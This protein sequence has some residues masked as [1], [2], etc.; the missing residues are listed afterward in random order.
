VPLFEGCIVLA[1]WSGSRITSKYPAKVVTIKT[2]G[3]IGVEFYDGIETEVDSGDSLA[4]L[5]LPSSLQDEVGLLDI[6]TNKLGTG[7]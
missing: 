1:R 3:I 6:Y 5:K 4:V 7:R 2:N